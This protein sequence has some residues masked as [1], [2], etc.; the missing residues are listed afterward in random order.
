MRP[1]GRDLCRTTAKGRQSPRL[2]QELQGFRRSCWAAVGYEPGTLNAPSCRA[3]LFAVRV[4][5]PD[6]A[7]RAD[8]RDFFH[9]WGFVTYEVNGDTIEVIVPDAAGERQ[10]RASSTST[11]RSG[12]DITRVSS[13]SSSTDPNDRACVSGGRG[14]RGR[15]NSVLVAMKREGEPPTGGGINLCRCR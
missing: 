2:W 14:S 1:P 5:L 15:W 9:R 12:E 10:G 7:L 11:S 6:L 4:R 3:R 13:L 8:L